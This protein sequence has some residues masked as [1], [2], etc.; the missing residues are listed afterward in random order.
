MLTVD[1]RESE[2]LPRELATLF[3][4]GESASR[5]NAWTAFIR[6]HSDLIL[7]AVR[8]FGRDHDARMDLYAHVLEELSR[9]DFRRLRSYPARGS[10]RFSY[11]LALVVRRLC[12]D[13]LRHVYG[14]SQGSPAAPV[15]QE[16]HARKR[17]VELLGENIQ[18]GSL[19]D[20]SGGDPES[21]LRARELEEALAAA[22]GATDP[23]DLLLLKLRFNDDL[24]AR[25][26]ARLMGFPTVF[27]VYRRQNAILESLRN[28]LQSRGFRDAQP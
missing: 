9:D 16:R 27:H 20:A 5:E 11:W 21:E 13:H 4:A 14:R 23:R 15:E 28:S 26:V 24:S 12:V 17:L 7:R 2:S 19:R 10:G 25:E 18:I 6:T 22:L 8:S 1:A 3:Q